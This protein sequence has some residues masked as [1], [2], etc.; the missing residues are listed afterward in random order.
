M[1]VIQ[2]N[3]FLTGDRIEYIIDENLAKVRGNLVEL[4]DKEGNILRTNFLDYNTKDSIGTFFR[5]DE[6]RV[7]KEC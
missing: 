2:E 4:F 3:T 5:S 1:Q 6:R 7:G